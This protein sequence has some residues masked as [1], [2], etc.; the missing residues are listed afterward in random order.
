VKAT[1]KMSLKSTI[2]HLKVTLG[3]AKSHLLK[4]PEASETLLKSARIHCKV[5]KKSLKRYL[6]VTQAQAT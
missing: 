6:K 5:A 2:N 3:S 4:V 1:S